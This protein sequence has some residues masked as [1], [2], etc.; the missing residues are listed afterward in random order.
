MRILTTTGG[1]TYSKLF[2]V[3]LT[4]WNLGIGKL[5]G[6]TRYFSNLLVGVCVDIKNQ[7]SSL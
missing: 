7:R 6:E 3:A 1:R 5:G 2:F 4:R